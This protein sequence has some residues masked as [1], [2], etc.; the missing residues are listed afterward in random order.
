MASDMMVALARATSD[1][2][3][4]FGHNCNRPRGEAVSLVRCPGRSF[5]PGEM[6]ERPWVHLPQTRHTWAVLAGRAGDDWGYQHGVNEKGVAAGYTPIR[7]RLEA[8]APGLS[9]PDFVRLAL[10]RATSACQAVEVLTDLIGRYGQG[11]F[12]GMGGDS[13]FLVADSRE[14]C[15]LEAAGRHWVVAEVG[16]VR[17]VTGASL[18]RQD[19]DRI[20]RGLSDL[21]ISRG[22]WPEDGCKLDFAGA[23]GEA[24]PDHAR[25]LRRWGMATLRLEQHSGRLDAAFLRELL[26][27]QADL[28]APEGGAGGGPQTAASLLVRLG[29]APGDLPV[30]W[31]AFGV[32]AASVYFPA[33]VIA[34]LPGAFADAGRG[35]RLWQTLQAWQDECRRDPRLWARL[36]SGLAGL[37]ERLDDHLHEMLPEANDLHRGGDAEGLARLAGSFL[38]HCVERF[39]EL[40]ALLHPRPAA[41]AA[42]WAGELVEAG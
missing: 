25:E 6:V 9:G 15:V 37:Q 10:E 41:R 11:A 24:G 42:A 30:C 19:W 26:R 5:A 14:A 22:W 39:E 20:S 2:H 4:F 28:L 13:A 1:Q 17:A 31:Y 7:T 35:C 36:H 29:P 3:T 33:F 21:A 40:A 27:D 12:A 23:L 8:E 16:S 18:L 38:Q 32:P 34:D